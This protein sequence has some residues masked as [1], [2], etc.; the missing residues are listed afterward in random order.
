[1]GLVRAL[2]F[3]SIGSFNILPSGATGTSEQNGGG[4]G[5]GHVPPNYFLN[6]KELVC[7]CLAPPPPPPTPHS[8]PKYRV[9]NVPPE[10]SELFRGPWATFG[11]LNF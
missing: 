11:H 2:M 10:I 6:Y 7:K 3:R 4:G 9:T 1:M 8:T 5:G